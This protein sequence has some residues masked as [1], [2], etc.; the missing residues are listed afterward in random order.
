MSLSI[1][2]VLTIIR[3]LDMIVEMI[4]ILYPEPKA[5]ETKLEQALIYFADVW[6]E[7]SALL[8]TQRDRIE[9]VI[10]KIVAL[11]NLLKWKKG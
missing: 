4:E 5:G 3:T 2:K 8:E 10:A 7:G 11:K 1:A 6:E 9:R